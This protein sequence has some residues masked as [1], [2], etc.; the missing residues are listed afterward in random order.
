MALWRRHIPKLY[1]YSHDMFYACRLCGC[2]L[3]SKTMWDEACPG[4]RSVAETA[5]LSTP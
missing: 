3:V 1:N 5:T 4:P 2:R